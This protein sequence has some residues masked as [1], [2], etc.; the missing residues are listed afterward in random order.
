MD[1]CGHFGDNF[2]FDV[3]L[4]EAASQGNRFRVESAIKMK[5]TS[6]T[7][8]LTMALPKLTPD[9]MQIASL[10]IANGA[11][12]DV[13]LMH[14]VRTD[15]MRLAAICIDNGAKNLNEAFNI[16]DMRGNTCLKDLM[17][18]MCI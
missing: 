18:Q 16:A 14:A 13:A 8:A 15:N 1:V 10:C 11:D 4:L 3:M 9:R 17:L 12:V 5:A 2:D 7:E 6:V